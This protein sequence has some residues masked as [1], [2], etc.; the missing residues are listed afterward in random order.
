MVLMSTLQL[1]NPIQI[2]IGMKGNDLVCRNLDARW[3]GS[4][5]VSPVP[6]S[7]FVYLATKTSGA[8][9]TEP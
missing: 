6:A 9:S 7:M 5:G 1:D 8:Y 3:H 4:H 2:F